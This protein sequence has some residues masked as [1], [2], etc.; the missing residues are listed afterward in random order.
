MPR[1][2][3][4]PPA[5]YALALTAAPLVAL[6]ALSCGGD[7]GGNPMGTIVVSL[8]KSSGDAQTGA[9]SA[10]L[11]EPLVVRV[12]DQNGNSLQ[13]RTV[14]WSVVSGGATLSSSSSSSNA[15]GMASVEVTLGA[16]AGAAT[17]RASIGS[18][19]V[20]FTATGLVPA[21]LTIVSGNDQNGKTLTP[22]AAPLVVR[23][24]AA[25]GAPV[26]GARVSFSVESGPATLSASTV[27]ADVAGQANVTLTGGTSL[28]DVS[29]RATVSGT[30]AEVVF[31]GRVTV[32]VIDMINTSFQG[33]SGGS[34]STVAV[35]DTVEWFN[36]DNAIG[37]HTATSS[38]TPA[39]G[40][41]FDSGNVSVNARF[42]FVPDA[43]GT[44][45]YF[46]EIHGASVMAGTLT[47]Q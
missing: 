8:A 47:A 28:G 44:W 15:S 29:V 5:R 24:T 38:S 20:D 37:T 7:G 32:F 31:S 34:A 45:D 39:G 41:A 4:P 21:T 1:F 6:L 23:V 11:L 36:R 14:S 30:A 9:V 13:N 25:A 27:S 17:I 10:T 16:A 22:F 18:E 26:P 33:P 19:Q 43:V 40:S 35:G 3:P 46:C 42:R 2:R 12:T